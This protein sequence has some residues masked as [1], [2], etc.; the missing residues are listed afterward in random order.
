MEAMILETADIDA[1]C[2]DLQDSG[3]RNFA[4]QDDYAEFIESGSLRTKPE[5]HLRAVLRDAV[6]AEAVS[7]YQMDHRLKSLALQQGN[8]LATAQTLRL[9]R[10]VGLLTVI[11]L[12]IAAVSAIEPLEKISKHFSWLLP[13]NL[14]TTTRQ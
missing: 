9:Q 11:A 1:V 7:I 4:W 3:E 12:F 14:I 10:V 5:R 6:Q 2:N 13:R 8:I